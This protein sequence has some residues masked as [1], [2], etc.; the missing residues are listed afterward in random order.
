MFFRSKVRNLMKEPELANSLGLPTDEELIQRLQFV[1]EVGCGNWGSVWLCEP[2]IQTSYDAFDKSL[3][4]NFAVKVGI[5]TSV[6]ICLMRA[7]VA[8]TPR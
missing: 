8:G 1:K 6:P 7:F 4:R 2:K 3:K 5:R